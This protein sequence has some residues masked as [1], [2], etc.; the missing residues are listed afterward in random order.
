NLYARAERNPLC[1][2]ARLLGYVVL[3]TVRQR[4]ECLL[5]FPSETE[6][7]GDAAIYTAQQMILAGMGITTMEACRFAEGKGCN[8]TAYRKALED[9]KPYSAIMM[10]GGGNFNDFYWED[11]PARIKT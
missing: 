7:K 8:A 10:A 11:Q 9:H 1:Q 5:T 6:N 3:A 4:S 2:H